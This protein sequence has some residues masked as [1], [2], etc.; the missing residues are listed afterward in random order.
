MI[1]GSKD[2]SD[3]RGSEDQRIGSGQQDLLNL[4]VSALDRQGLFDLAG[5]DELGQLGDNKGQLARP[6]LTCRQGA[7]L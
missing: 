6:D 2:Q 7:T 5:L 3:I 4:F 1:S